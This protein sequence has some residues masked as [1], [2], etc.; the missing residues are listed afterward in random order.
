MSNNTTIA[1]PYA[2]AA[3]AEALQ[4]KTIP[5]W[6]S[7]LLAASLAVQHEAVS[8]I[9]H[10]PH[11]N[12]ADRLGCLSELCGSFL[13][14]LDEAGRNFLQLLAD[15]NRLI[16]LPEIAVLF[17]TY[18]VEQEQ[19][20]Q[21]EVISA[22]PLVAEQQKELTAALKER[23]QREVTLDCKVDSNLIGGLIIRAGDL[24]I[25]GS[26]AGKLTRLSAELIN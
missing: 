2:K 25:D 8:L 9:L 1:R 3:F 10:S 22:L 23:L 19:T 16:A 4:H 12:N 15:N 18:R 5:A 17:Q 6:S 11:Y 20:A 13:E 14:P 7:L 24:V 21:V 26:V